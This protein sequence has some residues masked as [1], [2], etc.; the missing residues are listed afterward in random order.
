MSMYALAAAGK[1]RLG[2]R[3][4]GFCLNDSRVPFLYVA[5]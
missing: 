4:A 3:F 5:V 2:S 1:I